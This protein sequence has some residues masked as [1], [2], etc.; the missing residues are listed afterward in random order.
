VITLAKAAR[1]LD[2]HENTIRVAEREGRIRQISRDEFGA[3]V[4]T[5]ED[6]AYLKTIL[7][8]QPKPRSDVRARSSSASTR[9]R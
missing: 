6:I 5:P 7:R 3:R 8:P 9:A 1:L 2:V 4:F